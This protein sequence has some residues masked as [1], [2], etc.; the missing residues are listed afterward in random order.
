MLPIL[1]KAFERLLYNTFQRFFSLHKVTIQ[2][3]YGFQKNKL[4]EWAVLRIK[5]KIIENMEHK[6]Y[7]LGLVLDFSKAFHTT[8]NHILLY[9]LHHYGIRSIF[10]FNFL[11]N[12]YQIVT[13]DNH[14]SDRS[15]LNSTD[16][17]CFQFILLTL[18]DPSY[19]RT[20]NL[21]G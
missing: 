5:V 13:V 14:A 18:L 21:R 20:N 6:K 3:Q 9:K 15:A 19:P 12:R 2:A 17:Y 11:S 10:L 16:R 7:T 1:F 4:T 8:Q